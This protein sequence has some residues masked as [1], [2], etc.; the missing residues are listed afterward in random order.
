MKNWPVFFLVEAKVE[1]QQNWATRL[2]FNVVCTLQIT[3]ISAL[4]KVMFSVTT[5]NR[6]KVN[7]W[8]VYSATSEHVMNVRDEFLRCVSTCKKLEW[9]WVQFFSN[10]SVIRSKRVIQML[11]YVP[12]H[13]VPIASGNPC[14]PCPLS[15]V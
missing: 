11:S 5:H 13:S 6:E 15:R 14:P 3:L 9:N 4:C 8:S 2:F 12:F 7:L 10:M 1:D